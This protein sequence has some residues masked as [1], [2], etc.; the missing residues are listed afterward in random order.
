MPFRFRD[1]FTLDNYIVDLCWLYT[2]L[3]IVYLFIYKLIILPCDL[4]VF[5]INSTSAYDP[6]LQ[7]AVASIRKSPTEG[8]RQFCPDEQ[9]NVSL[10]FGGQV[11]LLQDRCPPPPSVRVGVGGGGRLVGSPPKGF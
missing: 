8:F 5:A 11:F 7:V 3:S 4:H 10:E 9:D 2:D 6:P 1:I